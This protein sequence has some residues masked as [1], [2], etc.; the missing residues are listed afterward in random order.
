MYRWRNESHISHCLPTLI[1]I[2]KR[3]ADNGLFLSRLKR[4]YLT[5]EERR[6]V[7]DVG[8]LDREGAHSLEA[9][10]PGVRGLYRHAH[11]LAVLTFAVE[12]LRKG[13]RMF[14]IKLSIFKILT[15]HRTISFRALNFWNNTTQRKKNQY[16]QNFVEIS[17]KVEMKQCIFWDLFFNPE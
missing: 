4:P 14:Y 9:G 5:I 8:D 10:L 3:E 16:L 15:I 2:G 13:E 12:N 11:E 1:C 17:K 7:V 6:V